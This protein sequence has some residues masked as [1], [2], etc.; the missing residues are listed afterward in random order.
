MSQLAAITFTEK[1][2]AELRFKLRQKL[3][4]TK[5][6]S[7]V[8][9]AISEFDQ[10]QVSTI[11]AFCAR[12]LRMRPVDAG[13]SPSFRVADEEESSLLFSRMWDAWLESMVERD[14]GFFRSLR[15]MEIKPDDL[16]ITAKK[17]FDNRDLFHACYEKL[18]SPKNFKN[19]RQGYRELA[20]L[21]KEAEAAKADA[22]GRFI[23]N[24]VLWLDSAGADQDRVWMQLTMD[25]RLKNYEYKKDQGKISEIRD[26][27]L[28][29]MDEVRFQPMADILKPLTGFLAMADAEKKRLE[30]LDFQDLL[31]K[32]RDLAKNPRSREYLKRRFKYLLV[33]EFQDTDPL[34]VELVFFLAEKEGK[35][36]ETLQEVE[37]EPGKLFLVGDPKQSIYRFRRADL[38]IYHEAGKIM[39]GQKTSEAGAG[40][41]GISARTAAL[42]E[43]VNLAFQQ[44]HPRS[45]TAS[46]RLISRWSRETIRPRS[47]P[48][49]QSR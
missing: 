7:W 42:L 4:E 2:A 17:I 23:R 48:R 32:A 10:A 40:W 34:Q 15:R 20:A 24:A 21:A 39:L 26:R 37:L 12:I 30:I 6:S 38:E 47:R 35:S 5:Q 28:K 41:T 44:Y 9:Q 11:H 36:V 3:G 1:A 46:S 27:A 8:A 13:V 19:P 45:R 33:D 22:L 49:F 25:S 16:K 14:P 31:L 18:T 29:L 43:W